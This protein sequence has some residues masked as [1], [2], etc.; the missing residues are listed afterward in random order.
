MK[1]MLNALRVAY[2]AVGIIGTLVCIPF[3]FGLYYAANKKRS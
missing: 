3:Y 2:Y 1:K